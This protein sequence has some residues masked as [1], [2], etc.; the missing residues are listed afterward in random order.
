MKTIITSVLGNEFGRTV[1][2]VFG[3][4]PL[5]RSGAAALAARIATRSLPVTIAVAGAGLAARY[6][7]NRKQEANAETARRSAAA[8]KGAAKRKSTSSPRAKSTRS[9]QP[10][11]A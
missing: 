2:K 5:V 1:A 3:D 9:A 8:R 4:N 7:Y 11:A 6:F 10:A